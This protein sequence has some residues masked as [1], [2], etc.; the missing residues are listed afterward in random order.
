MGLMSNVKIQMSNQCFNDQMSKT[1]DICDLDIMILCFP[2]EADLSP[3]LMSLGFKPWAE[4][5]RY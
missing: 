3:R 1:F 5:I 2:P 4:E